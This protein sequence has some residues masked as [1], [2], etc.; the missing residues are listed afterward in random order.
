MF[1]LQITSYMYPSSYQRTVYQLHSVYCVTFCY[2][3]KCD[4][5][6]WCILD[7][8][9]EA[10]F[11]L[12]S[13][14]HTSTFSFN[15]FGLKKTYIVSCRKYAIRQVLQRKIAVRADFNKRHCKNWSFFVYTCCELDRFTGYAFALVSYF[16]NFCQELT[17]MYI[18]VII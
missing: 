7:R 18:N 14:W 6:M 4:K 8:E 3:T 13:Q 2:N 5:K 11:W 1:E 16:L 9:H 10:A 15:R 17:L 12:V